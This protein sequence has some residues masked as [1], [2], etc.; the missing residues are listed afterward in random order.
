ML[1][2]PAHANSNQR[3]L[4]A[5]M[6]RQ[7]GFE[8]LGLLNEPSAASV[9]F[10]HASRNARDWKEKGKVLVYDLGGGTFDVSLVEM[11]LRTP[12]VLAS[13]GIATLGGDDFDEILAGLV[14]DAAG[15]APEERD[16]LSQA[17][18]FRLHEECREKKESLHPNTRRI[19]VDLSAVKSGWPEVSIPASDFYERCR[20]LVDETLHAV[21]DLISHEE[22]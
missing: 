16:E 5:E 20:P 4:T 15:V 19:Q 22:G 18:L 12:A 6:F 17:Q 10:G 9:E 2:V 3:F 1:G 21:E 14:L 8:V 13:E 11:G 7:A